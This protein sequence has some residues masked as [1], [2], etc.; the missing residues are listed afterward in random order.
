MQFRKRHSDGQVF[1]IGEGREHRIVDDYKQPEPEIG[2]DETSYAESEAEYQESVKEEEE[3]KKEQ[4][5]KEQDLRKA[6]NP[7]FVTRH[8]VKSDVKKMMRSDDSKID[9]SKN[10]DKYKTRLDRD[11]TLK[12]V[13]EAQRTDR[14]REKAIT[15]AEKYEEKAEKL[16]QEI[17]ET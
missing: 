13:K 2:D 4:Q 1:P 3:L 12:H 8:T 17:G 11:M 14:K 5:Q 6:E 10:F 15:K 7:S 9:K 16:K